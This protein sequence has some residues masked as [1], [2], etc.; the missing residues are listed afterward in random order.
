MESKICKNC[1]L[2]FTKLSKTSRK[3]WDRQLCCSKECAAK[4]RG[5]AWLKK[6]NI[7]KG[8]HLSIATEFKKGEKFMEDNVQWK[9]DKAS[10]FAKHMWVNRWFGKPNYCEWCEAT[11][12]KRFDWANI[13]GRYLR[14][15]KDWL[16]LCVP[17]H[18]KFDLPNT[19]KSEV[20]G[21]IRKKYNN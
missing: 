16:R 5:C 17:C 14:N 1:G 4:Y 3:L 9:G 11:N 19:N 18:R 20:T 12:R 15:R 8:Q 7:K 21:E 13:S 6:F 2:E 10:Y